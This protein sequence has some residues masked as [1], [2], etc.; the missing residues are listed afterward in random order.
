MPQ[1]K[2]PTRKYFTTL[3]E[4]IPL[5]DLVEIQKKSYHWFFEEGLKE[6]FDEI[7]PIT[8]FIGRDLQLSFEDYYLDEP[9]FDETQA[10]NKNI[11]YEAPLRVNVRLVNKR[12][13]E[14]K[15]HTG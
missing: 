14:V 3:R 1:V 4:A 9:K 13:N 2:T 10:K 11:S 5:T 12:T 8:D 7:S 15:E 6:L